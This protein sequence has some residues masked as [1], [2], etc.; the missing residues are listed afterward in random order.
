[1]RP[2]VQLLQAAGQSVDQD[3][4]TGDPSHTLIEL[5]ERH[6]CD[7]II[8]SAHGSSGFRG[9]LGKVAHELVQSSPVPVTVVRSP[10][11]DE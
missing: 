7:A 1:M 11:A 9:Q 3:V 10:D 6:A 4:A 2:A 5:V 8:L